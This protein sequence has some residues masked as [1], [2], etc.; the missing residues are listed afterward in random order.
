VVIQPVFSDLF[1]NQR[2]EPVDLVFSTGAPI[3]ETALAGFVQDGLTLE[4]MDGVRVEATRRVDGTT[5]VAMTDTA[6]FFALRYVPAGAYDMRA[7][8]DQDRDRLPDFF[9]A[10]DSTEL[11]IGFQDTAV[12]ELAVLPRD[13][14]PANLTRAEAIDSTKVRL[15]FDDHIA[16]DG[17]TGTARVYEMETDRQ[18]AELPL[19]H[20]SR[21]DSLLAAERVVADSIAAA[22]ELDARVDSLMQDSL[23]L[24]SLG[25]DRLALDSLRLDTLALDSLVRARIAA[26][27][28]PPDSAG[29]AGAAQQGRARPAGGR[30]ARE[31]PP[32]PS[33]DLFIVFPAPLSP[34]TEYRVEVEGVTNIQGVPGGGGSDEFETPR[35][36]E[37]PAEVPPDTASAAGASRDPPGTGPQVR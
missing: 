16:P 6:G 18:V 7:W 30:P 23:A 9:E 27:A 17:V 19:R 22:A 4:P 20:G 25:I 35:A 21:L 12:V 2:D 3:P 5:Y 11:A 24:D 14:T 37:P 34:G 31:G 1:N 10:Q 15:T 29:P 13:T 36:P 32:V 33:R 8:L 26:G 28:A